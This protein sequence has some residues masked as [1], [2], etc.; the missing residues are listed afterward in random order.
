MMRATAPHGKGSGDHDAGGIRMTEAKSDPRPL[1]SLWE[2][3]QPER[4][5]LSEAKLKASGG[6]WP[7]QVLHPPNRTP[8]L[9]WETRT[10]PGRKTRGPPRPWPP[11]LPPWPGERGDDR[12]QLAAHTAVRPWERTLPPLC[13]PLVSWEGTSLFPHPRRVCRDNAGTMSCIERHVK[14]RAAN[15]G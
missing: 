2:N 3:S 14:Q 9:F 13:F 11:W 10:F 12:G 5:G 4:F 8:C 15:V 6:A 7:G 1:G